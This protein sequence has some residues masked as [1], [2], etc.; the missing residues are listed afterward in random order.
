MPT[1]AAADERSSTELKLKAINLNT[2]RS[3]TSEG[4][5]KSKLNK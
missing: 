5:L 1:V 2:S 4:I 3:T